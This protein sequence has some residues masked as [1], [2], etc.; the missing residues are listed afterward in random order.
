MLLPTGQGVAGASAGA[1]AVPAGAGYVTGDKPALGCG[2]R[3]CG[4]GS[5][6]RRWCGGRRCHGH[7]HRRHHDHYYEHDHHHSGDRHHHAEPAPELPVKPPVKDDRKPVSDDRK[8]IEDDR[9]PIK[10]GHEEDPYPWDFDP[11]LPFGDEGD[12]DE[13]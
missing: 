6:G 3:R 8:P 12:G 4:D 5:W 11:W 10:D 2:D 7:H 13:G 9:E 1:S